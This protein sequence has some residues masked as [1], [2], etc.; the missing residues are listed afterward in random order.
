MAGQRYRGVG[1]KRLGGWG[2]GALVADR[3]TGET[4]RIYRRLGRWRVYSVDGRRGQSVDAVAPPKAAACARRLL[5][6]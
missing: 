6:G 3:S 2:I 1:T 5:R 4:L